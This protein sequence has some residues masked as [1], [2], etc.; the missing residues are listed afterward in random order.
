M[1]TAIEM[2]QVAGLVVATLFARGALVIAVI[3]VLSLPFMAYAHLA[4]AAQLSWHRHHGLGHAS[5]HA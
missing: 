3:V 1:M 2:L 5:H 4:R